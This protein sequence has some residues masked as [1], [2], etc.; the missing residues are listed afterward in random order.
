MSWWWRGERPIPKL[1]HGRERRGGCISVS[2]ITVHWAFR[3]SEYCGSNDQNTSS[4]SSP[5][6]PRETRVPLPTSK[7]AGRPSSKYSTFLGWPNLSGIGPQINGSI[8]YA[9]RWPATVAGLGSMP[10][11]NNTAL[12]FSTTTLT[13]SSRKQSNHSQSRFYVRR[14]IPLLLYQRPII[15]LVKTPG[16]RRNPQTKGK[17]AV[18]SSSRLRSV[19]TASIEVRVSNTILA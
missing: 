2:G 3:F 7:V 12:I 5:S 18:P 4:W 16:R 10:K 9:Q 1:R 13:G 14:A 11:C 17:S 19:L 8:P 15:E 6:Q